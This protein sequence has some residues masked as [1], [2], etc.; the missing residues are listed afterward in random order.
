M[1]D[2]A[3]EAARLSCGEA[4]AKLTQL[5]DHMEEPFLWGA[6]SADK[7]LDLYQNNV[8]RFNPLV[9]RKMYASLFMFG[10][11]FRIEQSGTQTLLFVPYAFRNELDTGSYPYPF[12]H[13]KGKWDSYQFATELVLFIEDGKLLGAMR[14]A[15]QDTS[16]PFTGHT[17]DGN[18]SWM[19][20]EGVPAPSSSVLYSKLLSPENAMVA[21]LNSAF[22]ALE[23]KARRQNCNGCHSPDNAAKASQLVLLNY[24]NQAIYAR[25]AIVAEL[26][27][28]TMPAAGGIPDL[29]ARMELLTLARNFQAAAEQALRLEGERVR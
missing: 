23:E 15:K 26:E 7:P 24:P 5:R 1:A 20:P 4:L 8:T 11:D 25:N 9:W 10:S 16:R 14:G 21:P 29:E 6:Q 13:S 19:T 17:F 18:W 27:Q 22:R 3:D 2:R 12:W 28:N